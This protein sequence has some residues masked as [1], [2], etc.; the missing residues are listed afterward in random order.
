VAE[1]Q[2]RLVASIHGRSYA[3][4]SNGKGLTPMPQWFCHQ[5]MKA[6]HAKNRRQIRLLNECW[7]FYRTRYMEDSDANSAGQGST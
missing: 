4:A 3:V 6:F 2:K 1:I 7:F 5:L